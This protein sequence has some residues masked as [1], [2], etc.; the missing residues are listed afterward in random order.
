MENKNHTL[1]E[2]DIQVENFNIINDTVSD[3]S[4]SE[5]DQQN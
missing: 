1:S 2:A 3:S 5:A 4:D